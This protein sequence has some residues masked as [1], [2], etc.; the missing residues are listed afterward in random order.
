MRWIN[1]AAF[2]ETRQASG[3]EGSRREQVRQQR[4]GCNALTIGLTNL[5]FVLKE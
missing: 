5:P 2:I 3:R 4:F 1:H